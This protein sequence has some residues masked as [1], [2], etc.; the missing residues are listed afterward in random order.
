MKSFMLLLFFLILLLNTSSKIIVHAQT[1]DNSTCSS[2]IDSPCTKLNN[3]LAPCGSKFGPPPSNIQAYEYTVDSESLAICMC[4]QNA[5]NTLSSCVFCYSNGNT[6]IRAADFTD[7]QKTCKS[8]GISF[9]P[10]I[11]EPNSSNLSNTAVKVSIGIAVFIFILGCILIWIWYKKK[12]KAMNKEKEIKREIVLTEQEMT[13]HQPQPSSENESYQRVTSYSSQPPN[14]RLS[15]NS[16]SSLNQRHSNNNSSSPT[17]RY[18]NN[19]SSTTQRYSNNSSSPTQRYS[20]N[21]SSPTQRYSNNNSQ[22]PIQRLSSNNSQPATRLSSNSS[23]GNYSLSSS[24]R[25][26]SGYSRSSSEGLLPS[27]EP[28]RPG[29][30]TSPGTIQVPS[31]SQ[32]FAPF[33]NVPS[34]QPHFLPQQPTY[35]PPTTQTYIRPS[36]TRNNQPPQLPNF[37]NGNSLPGPDPVFSRIPPP[38]PPPPPRNY[39]NNYYGSNQHFN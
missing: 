38:P 17:Q 9:G 33:Y 27:I 15:S 8:Y 16:S 21:S 23:S 25:L 39:Y 5:Y 7:Y 14:Q 6:N 34:Q 31:Q 11:E 32:Y 30:F 18:S 22:L 37:N 12:S 13:A 1:S 24:E 26:P 2:G 10:P 28:T 29:L 36:L 3:L 4:D 20:N 19:S 35:Q